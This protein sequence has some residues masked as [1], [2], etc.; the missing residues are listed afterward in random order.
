[1]LI[2][3]AGVQVL[4]GNDPAVQVNVTVGATRFHPAEFG[5]GAITYVIEGGTAAP[6]TVME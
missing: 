6:V 5:V 3:P 1:M 4:I 2:V